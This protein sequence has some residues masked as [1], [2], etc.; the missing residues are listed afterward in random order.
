MKKNDFCTETSKIML[1]VRQIQS[2]KGLFFLILLG[3]LNF[4]Y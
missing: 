3:S 1:L 2:S 4:S